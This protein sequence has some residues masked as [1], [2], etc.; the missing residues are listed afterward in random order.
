MNMIT[1]NGHNG[2]TGARWSLALAIILAVFS[3]ALMFSVGEYNDTIGVINSDVIS[4][5]NYLPGALKYHDFDFKELPIRVGYVTADNGVVAE[6]MTMGV[7]FLYL[8][9]Y[10]LAWLR[11]TARLSACC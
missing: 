9:F 6:K 5:Y 4:Y 3:L 2:R 7:S 8:P 11:N 1:A 10:L